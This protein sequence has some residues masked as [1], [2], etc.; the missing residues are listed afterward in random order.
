MERAPVYTVVVGV[1]GFVLM[2]TP[3]AQ[4]DEVLWKGWGGWSAIARKVS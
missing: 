3:A 2:H 1:G 4:R